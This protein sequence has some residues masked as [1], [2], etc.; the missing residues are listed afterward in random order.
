MHRQ[1]GGTDMRLHVTPVL[2]T[3]ASWLLVAPV[4][5]AQ[6]ALY[7]YQSGSEPRWASPENPTAAK[8][9]GG[10][11]NKGGK[12]HAFETIAAG[13]AH[14]LADIQGAGVIDRMWIT[15]SDRSPEMLRSLRLDIYWDGEAK[16]A[17]S[18][19]LGDFFGA[20]AGAQVPMETELVASPEG[21]SFVSYV[22]MPFR[23][24]ARVVVSNESGKELS[25]I[26]Y[27]VDFRKLERQPENALYFHAYWSRD[28]ATKP[29]TAFEI[30]P[31]VQ[32]R[33]RFLGTMVTTFTNPAYGKTW[34]G[35]GEAKIHLD[36]DRDNASLVGTGTE[37]YIGSA[38]GQGAYINRFQGA[39][40][41]DEPRGR[42][43]YYRFHVPDPIFF[44]RDIRVELQQIGGA[45]KKDVIAM[46]ERGVPLVPITIDPG[47]RTN[48]QQLLASD[49]PTPV[50]RP[51]LPDGWTNFYR[52]D[53]VSAVALF[54]LDRPSNG[55]PVIAPVAER[56]AA[57]RPPA[58]EKKNP[59]PGNE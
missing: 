2:A 25:L 44:D 21:R 39:P 41:A 27:D 5:A 50:T 22:P 20:G 33:G 17:V 38:W 51:G 34:W 18:V 30:L 11:E 46:L 59:E 58:A 57:L 9:M 45:L 31:R 35:E 42:W 53:D 23:T 16:P 56:I 14:V 24:G 55:L 29:G 48:F 10:R 6:S 15:V 3:L 7:E 12:G 8:G 36:G 13:K 49:P 4:A 37:D 52:S 26:F 28:R 43:S 32:G 1:P 19:P 54:Y 40:V 47:R